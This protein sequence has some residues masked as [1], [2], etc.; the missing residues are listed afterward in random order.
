MALPVTYLRTSEGWQPPLSQF[1]HGSSF[2]HDPVASPG[3]LRDLGGQPMAIAGQVLTD[4]PVPGRP[5]AIIIGRV[6]PGIT[7]L[8][9]VQDGSE[10][11]RHLD[12]HFGAW[13]A[14][15][16]HAGPFEITGSGADGT[17][18]A[19]LTISPRPGFPPN[20][21]FEDRSDPGREAPIKAT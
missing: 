8:T 3:S 14:C 21:R 4:S 7:H 20:S 17:T 13:I 5:A 6:A 1:M 10:D 18:L 12:S 9:L 11:R 19:R 2:G 16:E 15:T